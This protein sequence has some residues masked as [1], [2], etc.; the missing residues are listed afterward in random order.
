MSMTCP[1]MLPLKAARLI[2]GPQAFCLLFVLLAVTAVSGCA[3]KSLPRPAPPPPSLSD[4]ARFLRFNHGGTTRESRTLELRSQGLHSWMEMDSGLRY[5]LDYV[6]SKPA[7]RVAMTRHGLEVTWGQIRFSIEEMLRLLPYLDRRPELL[8]EHFQWFALTPPPLMTGY[9]TPEIE[10]SLTPRPGYEYPIY[11][12][13]SDLRVRRPGQS[14]VPAVYRVENGRVLPYHTR[15]QVDLGKVLAGK[16]LEIAWAK[17]PVDVFYLQIEGQGRLHL[18]D[19]SVRHVVYGAKNGHAFEGLGNIL[20][21][22]GYLTKSRRGQKFVREF[23]SRH[24]ELARKLMAENKSYVFFRFDEHP[25][26]GAIGRPLTPM[27]SV[28]V[29]PGLL[30]LGS[31]LVLDADIPG[32]DGTGQRRVH[33]LV[34]AQD[35]GSAIKGARLDYFI[36]VGHDVE[37]VACHVYSRATAYLLLSKQAL[38]RRPGSD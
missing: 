25:S 28:A 2:L 34:L 38:A 5:S 23:C 13:P 33:G 6:R 15:A 4:A 16:G 30:P 11:G 35:T 20:Y 29:D 8:A 7:N 1:T 3:P 19:G 21:R 31:M 26:L 12:V 14:G 17:D 22:R 18:P 27:V 9:F 36:G 37:P 32:P 24:P 10:A